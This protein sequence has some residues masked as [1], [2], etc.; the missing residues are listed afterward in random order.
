MEEMFSTCVQGNNTRNTRNF[1]GKL[2]Q[3]YRETNKALKGLSYL[4]P[5]IWNNIG[6]V[7]IREGE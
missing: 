7:T 1:T 4:R 5:F 2:S 3:P 6:I